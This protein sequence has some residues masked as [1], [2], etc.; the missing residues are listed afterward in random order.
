[1]DLEHDYFCADPPSLPLVRSLLQDADAWIRG[2]LPVIKKQDHIVQQQTALEWAREKMNRIRE[3]VLQLCG[4]N[5]ALPPPPPVLDD[6]GSELLALKQWHMAATL[7]LAGT[8]WIKRSDAARRL[9]V[10]PAEITRMVD[11]FPDLAQT[12]KRGSSVNFNAL[13]DKIEQRRSAS[14]R[15]EGIRRRADQRTNK[16]AW[17]AEQKMA[18]PEATRSIHPK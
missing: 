5:P 13:R 10:G 2:W 11:H 7:H 12:S 8:E 16:D 3:M 18:A 9:G 14:L 6:P 1:M 15:D 4:N 17:Q